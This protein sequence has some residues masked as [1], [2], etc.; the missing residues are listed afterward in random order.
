MGVIVDPDNG[1]L[2]SDLRDKAT[3]DARMRVL[4]PVGDRPVDPDFGSTLV[5]AMDGL[6][7][8]LD[9]LPA[10]VQNALADSPYYT[11]LLVRVSA[12]ADGDPRVD[13]YLDLADGQ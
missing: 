9:L 5:E 12:D 7:A 13:V 10:S 4:T 1:R 11:V 8:D 2:V 6:P 3:I